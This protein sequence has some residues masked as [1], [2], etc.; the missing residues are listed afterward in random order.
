[1]A[2]RVVDYLPVATETGANIQNQTNYEIDAI[3]LTGHQAGLAKSASANKMWRQSSVMV[4]AIANMLSEA[5]DIDLLDD[6]DV[7]ALK[8]KLQAV[9]MGGR[10]TI[11]TAPTDFYVS[12]AGSDGVAADGLSPSSAWATPQ[13]AFN[14]I[15]D[16]YDLNGYPA[17]IHIAA[18][19]GYPGVEL[20][21]E[22]VGSVSPASLTWIG[23][24]ATATV[25]NAINH[26]CFVTS[27]GVDCYI[28]DLGLTAS[29]DPTQF[30]GYALFATQGAIFLINHV[31]FGP[32]N[33]HM[34]ASQGSVIQTMGNQDNAISIS[35]GAIASMYS[36]YSSIIVMYRTLIT[37]TGNPAFSTATLE[38]A[39]SGAISIPI[40][41]SFAGAA[42]G[43]R[44]W[45]DRNSYIN[46]AG[47]PETS[48]PGNA[49]GYIAPEGDFNYFNGIRS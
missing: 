19:T 31:N 5:L 11:M 33:Y 13:H 28:H 17:N 7:E 22:P 21:A 26:N 42:T 46:I 43:P 47:R 27:S 23:A 20:Y 44:F 37:V 8:K 40:E 9:V 16:L 38:A 35:G 1:M 32:A 14:Q 3:R 49:S 30:F 25:I 45:V 48:I 15:F 6:G 12:G 41:S 24:G 18:G 39:S 4:A 36:S 2:T 29:G 34:A 10:T